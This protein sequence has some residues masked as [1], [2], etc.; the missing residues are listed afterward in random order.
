MK[1]D[2]ELEEFRSAMEV[3]SQFEEGFNWSS[4]FAAIFIAMLIMPGAMYM[5]LLAGQGIGPAAQWVT[6]ILFIEVA[7][8]AHRN[9]K[10]AEI[11]VLFFMSGAALSV[12][13]SG[14]L[15]NQFFV[16]SDAAMEAGITGYL[17]HWWA[18]G[19]ESESYKSRTFFHMDWLPAIGLIVFG[20]FFSQISNLILGYGLFRVT[21]DTEKLPFPLAP[22]GAQGVMALAGDTDDTGKDGD[23]SWR[24]R[25]F[26]IGGA[27]GL[28]FGV[29]YL[30]LPTVTGALLDKPIMILPIPFSDFTPKTDAYLPAV[31]TG[32][33]WDLG[34][35]LVGMVLPFF[36]MLGSFIGL[37]ITMVANPILHVSGILDSW[38]TGDDTVITLYKNNVDFYFSFTIGV[39]LVIAG[40][41]MLQIIKSLNEWRK[42]RHTEE[43]VTHMGSPPEGRGDIR[44]WIVLT[45]YLLTTSVYILVAGF[46]IDWHRGVMIVMLFLGFVYT[47]IISYATARLEG[48][49]GEV[50]EIPF[51]REAMLIFSGYKGVAVWFIPMP[52]SNYGMMTV[53]YRQ[54][55]LT[56]TKF[57]SIWK[58]S[59]VLYP[60]ILISSIFFANFIWGLAEVPSAI[61]PFADRM[62][63]LQARNQC[64]M[65]SA[66]LGEYSIF[67]EAFDWIYLAAGGGFGVLL[68]TVL[69]WLGMPIFLIYGVVRGLGQ[70]MPHVIIPQFIGALIGRYY[71]QRK[72]GLRWRQYVPV[73]TAG[74]AC[75]AGLITTVGVGVTFLSKAVIELPY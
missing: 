8:R 15:W 18:P 44:F 9:L 75:G 50:V 39:S 67:E 51:I 29:I 7:R 38:A 57:T 19:A 59:F 63:E 56:G 12:P 35:L 43:A 41:G 3:P 27:I 24:W 26:S 49:V 46:L 62:W 37:I 73:V 45:C 48:I 31:A 53:F 28:A 71:F 32:M 17:P 4:L 23:T 52:M 54:C 10:R 30:L 6:V 72:L 42:K 40:A 34:N 20:T 5:T 16:S 14:L 21:S 64:I 1:I 61:Y 74:F 2:R 70:S 22:I 69:S 60:I 33:S 65:Y 66:T 11:F 68:F 25:V 13:F 47:P 58:A 36:A 55:E